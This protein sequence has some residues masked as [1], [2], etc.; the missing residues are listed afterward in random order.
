MSTDRELDVVFSILSNSP[1]SNNRR[2]STTLDFKTCSVGCL[3]SLLHHCLAAAFCTAAMA[4][5]EYDLLA[6]SPAKV[7]TIS[8]TCYWRTEYVCFQEAQKKDV[9]REG[10]GVSPR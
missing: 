4:A 5:F 3:L 7:D 10:T 8:D 2:P 6:C 1:L 9:G